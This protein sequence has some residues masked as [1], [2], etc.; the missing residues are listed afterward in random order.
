ML[1]PAGNLVCMWHG[2]CHHWLHWSPQDPDMMRNRR[3]WSVFQEYWRSVNCFRVEILKCE[4]IK[5][6]N[7]CWHVSSPGPGAASLPLNW[8]STLLHEVT[9][10][11]MIMVDPTSLPFTQILAWESNPRTW[12]AK[13]VILPL[14]HQD[15]VSRR[16]VANQTI[17]RPKFPRCLIPS[18]WHL[19]V[20]Y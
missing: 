10:V 16:K 18:L 13:L 3:L 1:E 9:L 17:S 5:P 14:S 6:T 8:V 11:R 2:H 20:Q 12:H 19:P 7:H 4:G 15:I